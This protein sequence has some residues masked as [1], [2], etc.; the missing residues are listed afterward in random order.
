MEW[1]NGQMLG[2]KM[3][4]GAVTASEMCRSGDTVRH[5]KRLFII[6]LVLVLAAVVS[7]PGSWAQREA[8]ARDLG[9]ITYADYSDATDWDPSIAFSTEA[10]FLPNVYEPLVWYGKGGELRSGLATSWKASKDGKTWTFRIRRGVK[11]H[12]GTPLTAQ[13]VKFSIDRTMKL[14]KGAAY[15][16][17]P[18]DRIEVVDRYTVRFRLKF[19]APIDLIATAQY[20]GWIFSPKSAASGTEWFQQ[21]RDAGSGPYR[22]VRWDKGQQIL[23][24]RFTDYW[25][26]WKKPYYSKV[27]I[28]ITTE[29]STRIQMLKRGEAQFAAV[30]PIEAIPGLKKQRN[31]QVLRYPAW[32]NRLWLLNTQ[33]GPT[34]DVRVR[35]AL[36]YAFDYQTV[37]R[38]VY[39]GYATV[40]R[41]AVPVSMWGA[42]PERSIYRF[43][44]DRARALL[45]EAGYGPNN[46]VKLVGRYIAGVAT[47]EREMLLFQRNLAKIGVDLELEPGPWP[48][49]WA[50]AKSLETA[51]NVQSMTWWPTYATPNDW[52]IGLFKSETPTV[53]NLS[54][55]SNPRYD[56][57]IDQGVTLEATNRK[58]AIELYQK[59]QRILLQEAAAIFSVD[60]DKGVVKRR[61]VTGYSY[62][63]AYETVFFYNLRRR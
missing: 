36:S 55:Y 3:L 32:L 13:A 61:E 27:V 9:T 7:V 18:V 37:A 20:A 35:R 48:A 26:G 63:P 5:R 8:G 45:A 6:P 46:R 39:G 60:I 4:A 50:K 44:L 40:A 12:D 1:G 42:L 23:L 14:G 30:I 10:I 29:P 38:H 31:I 16:W 22:V 59:A 52:L 62:N 56:A 53:F 49:I 25:Q 34:A 17:A 28:R 21:G 41:G 58:K 33:K 43:D 57:L 15:I 2:V 51:P 11:F 54:H 19:A 47:M 24:A